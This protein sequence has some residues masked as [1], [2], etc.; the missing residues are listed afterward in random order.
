MEG[1]N[2]FFQSVKSLCKVA[3]LSRPLHKTQR[4]SA[5]KRIVIMGNGPS[6][7]GFEPRLIPHADI[8]AVNFALNSEKIR[9]AK[10]D[11]YVLADPVFFA[12]DK[13]P[14]V[15]ELW[16]NIAACDWTMTLFVPAKYYKTALRLLGDNKHVAPASFNAVGAEGYRSLLNVL[17]RRGCAMPRPRNV[18]VPAIMCA[19]AAGYSEII[20]V[21]AD[22]NWIRDL[23]VTDNN[24]V[25]SVQKHFYKD[26]ETELKR[27][28]HVYSGIK[29][30]QVV[31]NFATALQSYHS[32]AD[33]A[34]AEGVQIY[35]ATPGSFIDAFPRKQISDFIK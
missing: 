8:L 14:N 1:L 24:E 25:I 7:A 30:H 6:L 19:I 13:A 16:L 11:C 20:L 23:E 33:F 26:S 34:A 17:F 9:E 12:D 2:K 5:N 32:I 3:L 29:L 22:H 28:A 15:E 27:I 10:P 21:G 18:L 4:T 35:N 31:G